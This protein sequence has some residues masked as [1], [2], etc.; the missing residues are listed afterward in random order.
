MLKS[1]AENEKSLNFSFFLSTFYNFPQLPAW[2]KV[3]EQ[4]AF[5]ILRKR[6]FF[7]VSI[8]NLV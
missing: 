1:L 3:L 2:R 7:M 6:E 5:L 8:V 4:F